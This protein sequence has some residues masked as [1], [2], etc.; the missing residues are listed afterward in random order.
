MILG[1]SFFWHA[2]QFPYNWLPTSRSL[3]DINCHKSWTNLDNICTHL[4]WAAVQNLAQF[5][6]YKALI[7]SV[8]NL[9]QIKNL[10]TLSIIRVMWPLWT[11]V[12][13]DCFLF[14][15]NALFNSK[16]H[17]YCTVLDSCLMGTSIRGFTGS[18]TSSLNQLWGSWFNVHVVARLLREIPLLLKTAR[19]ERLITP[20]ICLHD[21]V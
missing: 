8:S 17:F 1:K 16:S 11:Y 2:I 18:I 3:F 12:L 6:L 15:L 13:S 10:Q 4:L 21:A 9:M 19:V 14:V 5:I 20:S 7:F